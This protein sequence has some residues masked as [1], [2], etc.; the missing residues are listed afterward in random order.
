MVKGLLALYNKLAANFNYIICQNLM[1]HV[2]VI[3]FIFIWKLSHTWRHPS[4]FRVLFKAE[5]DIHSYS[6][7][8]YRYSRARYKCPHL[9]LIETKDLCR[10]FLRYRIHRVT[11]PLFSVICLQLF[12]RS[13]GCSYYTEL[14]SIVLIIYPYLTIPG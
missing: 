6:D 11:F 5:G 10:L 14:R 1:R 7:Y 9:Q 2:T 4:D 13:Q 3:F 12:F 8:S